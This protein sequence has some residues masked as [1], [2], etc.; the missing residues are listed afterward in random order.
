M[1]EY[2]KIFILGMARS[3][4]EAAKLLTNKNNKVLI[5]D[6][7]EQN[8]E[9]VKELKDLGVEFVISNEPE[10]ILDNSY[11]VVVK[12]PGI[13][14]EH[15]LV[16]KAKKLN[17]PVINEVEVAYHYLP[18]DITII[19]ITG[20]NGKTTTTTIIYE[21]LKAAK[22][23]VH[24]A[25][26]IG[27]PLCSIVNHIKEGD[28][29]VIEISSHQLVDFD[30]FKT[31]IAILTNLFE[32]HL[33]FFKTYKNYIN[34]KG[35]IFKY[36]THNNLAII[37]KN[38]KD[39][40]M[41]TKN[42]AAKKIYFSINKKTD[43]Y[44]DN[45]IIYYN[46]EEIIKV[47]NIKIK[48]NHN[49]ENIMCAIMVVKEFNVDN[50]VIKK[51]LKDFSGV[52]HRIEY[53]KELNS[54][55][56]YNDSKSTNVNATKM[57]LRSF[58]SPII[59]ILGGLNRGLPFDDLEQD[60]KYVKDIVCYGETKYIIKKFADKINISCNV[61]DNLKQAINKSY[62]LSNPKDIILF[63]PA[64]ASWDQYQ[65]FEERG[66]QFKKIVNTLK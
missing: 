33:D 4:Y 35:R 46:N 64:C 30:K 23:S 49:Y 53:V 26:N 43:S 52:E 27:F 18:K 40:L 3:G 54:R 20:S 36:H 1:W 56:F 60:M 25:G 32:T 12:N 21:I 59:L 47:E 6:M 50:E 38:N 9:H 7:K 37:N 41:L 10:L 15:P 39:S 5:T 14:K 62:E 66:E 24:L 65:D 34:N 63:S 16:I 57:A 17:I 19:G 42:I 55:T 61:V 48:G 2:K 44:L 31:N 45:N 11:D 22:K 58:K 13:N 8:E 51:V 28:I 29:L